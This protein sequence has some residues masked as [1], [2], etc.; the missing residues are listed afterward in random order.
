M[1]KVSATTLQQFVA[2][3]VNIGNFFWTFEFHRVVLQ[4][5][6]GEVEIFMA[7][8]SRIFLRITSW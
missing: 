7:Y 6:A 5:I 4:H 8:A 1:L 2:D 3:A